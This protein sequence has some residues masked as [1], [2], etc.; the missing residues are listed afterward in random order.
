VE[1]RLKES[2]REIANQYEF[3]DKVS[4]QSILIKRKEKRKNRLPIILVP[5][6]ALV[7]IFSYFD[8]EHGIA[9]LFGNEIIQHP[10]HTLVH[11]GHYYVPIDEDVQKNKLE[12][13]LGEVTR[14]G[15]WKFPEEGDTPEYIPGTKYYSV[16]G[17][18]E[19]EKIAVEIWG[20]KKQDMKVLKYQVL[21]RKEPVM[22]VNE[23]IVFSG[24]SDPKEVSVALD[25]IREHIPF[26]HEIKAA[27]LKT[28]SVGMRNDG[29]GYLVNTY[30]ISTDV[31]DGSEKVIFVRQY[32]KGYD[33]SYDND[34]A[35]EKNKVIETFS[36]N[37][38]EWKA[39]QPKYL[40]QE[41]K[42]NRNRQRPVFIGQKGDIVFEVASQV[43]NVE[44]VKKYL[45]TLTPTSENK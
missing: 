26:F 29:K 25:N 23:E 19:K 31:R 33:V 44:Q 30:Y 32:E 20:G 14:I 24:K 36:L 17:V 18:S 42:E 4:I 41:T 38:I 5:V 12:D 40:E 27:D 1:R 9:N 10:D 43:Y 3:P 22:K 6:A 39:Y 35:N 2:I 21:E 15:N 34:F 8:V 16:Q 11:D 28:F 45:E 37:G 13:K 7:F